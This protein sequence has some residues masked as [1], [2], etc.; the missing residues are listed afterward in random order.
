MRE[1]IVVRTWEKG[2][3]S[4]HERKDYSKNMRERVNVRTWEKDLK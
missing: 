1:K 4:E 2:L 3:R